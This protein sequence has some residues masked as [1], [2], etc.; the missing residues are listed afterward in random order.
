MY[1]L[2]ILKDL[3]ITNL[4]VHGLKHGVIIRLIADTDGLPYTYYECTVDIITL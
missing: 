3:E 2:T 1:F 4:V